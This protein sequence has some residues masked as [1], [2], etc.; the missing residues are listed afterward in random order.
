MTESFEEH[1]LQR[2]WKIYVHYPLYTSTTASYSSAAYYDVFGFQTVEDFWKYYNCI[3]AP[4]QVFANAVRPRQKLGGRIIEGFGIFQDGVDPEWEKTPGGGH[5]EISGITEGEV[6]DSL[7]E[8]LC[9]A[10]IGESAIKSLSMVG[11]RVVDKTKARKPM[12][13][14]EIWLLSQEEALKGEVL[15]AIQRI[16]RDDGHQCQEFPTLWKNH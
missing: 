13:R 15:D 4:S 1:P 16:F 9:L 11:I 10:L 14:V 12:Y 5:W 8:S 2:P 7:W 6:L 3:P